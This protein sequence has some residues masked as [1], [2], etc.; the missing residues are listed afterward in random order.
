ASKAYQSLIKDFNLVKRTKI[1]ESL[2]L[3]N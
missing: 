1:L 2:Y 3:N